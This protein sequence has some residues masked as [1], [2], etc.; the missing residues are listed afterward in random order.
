[1]GWRFRQRI[2]L[3]PGFTLNLSPRPSLS[4]GVRGLRATFG[5]GVRT[6]VGL[7]GSGL[8][9]TTTQGARH[10][11]ASARRPPDLA[12]AAR[13]VVRASVHL[14]FWSFVLWLVLHQTG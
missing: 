3:V 14:A 2:N 13:Q 10:R 12:M 9:Y 4:V 1:M 5:R 8:T 6:M 11:A 7:S